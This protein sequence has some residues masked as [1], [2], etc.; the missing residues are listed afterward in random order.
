MGNCIKK[1]R[2]VN[3]HISDTSEMIWSFQ[4]KCIICMENPVQ[5]AVLD[6][7][8]LHF[9]IRCLTSM[10]LNRDVSKNYLNYCP[11]CRKKIKGYATFTPN[12]YYKSKLI[13]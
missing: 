8:H 13:I 12:F 9:C 5:A 6:C 7:G 11:I 3:N 10:I 4:T 1:N 2:T